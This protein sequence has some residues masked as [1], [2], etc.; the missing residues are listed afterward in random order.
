[1][2]PFINCDIRLV[3]W[4]W[5]TF[6]PFLHN[7]NEWASLCGWSE[8]FEDFHYLVLPKHSLALIKLHYLM[9]AFQCLRSSSTN[10]R[11][12]TSTTST[13]RTWS[14][15]WCIATA[16][17]SDSWSAWWS[18]PCKYCAVLRMFVSICYTLGFCYRWFG[19]FVWHQFEFDVKRQLFCIGGFG[20]SSFDL[21]F[22]CQ[23]LCRLYP[24][25]LMH[26]GTFLHTFAVSW[27]S[28]G[29]FIRSMA[30]PDIRLWGTSRGWSRH[31]S[32]EGQLN[33][34]PS[35]SR[36][37]LRWRGPRSI[38]LLDGGHGRICPGFATG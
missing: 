16:G 4:N 2:G 35:I 22:W 23:F 11:S 25:I 12:K 36:L 37:F 17:C 33:V 34:F 27:L 3:S 19:S 9:F 7:A 21:W 14:S 38:A 15:P 26:T 6:R 32:R 31:S 20:A 5:V 10:E 18:T 29:L 13:W 1:M 24:W 8:I 28:L 30:Y